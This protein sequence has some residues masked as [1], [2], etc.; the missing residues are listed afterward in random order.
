[1][2]AALEAVTEWDAIIGISYSSNREG[3]AARWRARFGNKVHVAADLDDLERIAV[4]QIARSLARCKTNGQKLIVQEVGGFVV[5]L[6]HKYFADQLWLV[7]G[8]VELTKQGVWRADKLKLGIPVL[9]CA[10]SELKRLEAQRCGETIARCLDGVARELGLSLAGRR[11]CVLGAGWIGSGV[12]RALR[13]LDMIPQLVD[14]DPLKLVE[15]R[16]DG[17]AASSTLEHI[18]ECQLVVGATGQTSVTAELIERL[19]NYALIASG[20]SRQI[21]I[22]VRYLNKH[23]SRRL[24]AAVRAFGLGETG[25]RQVLLV[26]DGYPANFVPGSASVAD[27]IV[28]MILAEIIV[29]LLTLMRSEIPAGIHRISLEQERQCAELWLSLRDASTR[30]RL[31]PDPIVPIRPVRATTPEVA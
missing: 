30:E 26:N 16:L 23:P 11:A 6:L 12:A 28:E 13:R 8:V 14:R 15:A 17:F 18:E 4:E 22:D 1:M 3:L 7:K 21:E 27:E 24:G 19:P 20:S 9:H 31:L 2:L 5:P 10:D 29:L 25:R